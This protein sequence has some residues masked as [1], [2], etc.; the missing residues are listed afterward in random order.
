MS[1]NETERAQRPPTS[2]GVLFIAWVVGIFVALSVIVGIVA[3]V[4]AS[5]HGSGSTDQCFTN[6]AGVTTCYTQ[7]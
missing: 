2:R 5:H 1:E 4:Q 6:Y 3:A 7:P